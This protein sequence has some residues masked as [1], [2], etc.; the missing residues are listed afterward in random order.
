MKLGK[1]S[2]VE[3]TPPALPNLGFFELGTNLRN[4]LKMENVETKLTTIRKISVLLA[5]VRQKSK[6]SSV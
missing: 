3:M 2:Q 4:K 1:C 5:I 6:N